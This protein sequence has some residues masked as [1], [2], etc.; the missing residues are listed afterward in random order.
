MNKTL[1]FAFSSFAC[2]L[3]VAC[4]GSSSSDG[5]AQPGDEQD[6]KG[7]ACAPITTL[8]CAAGY[9]ST[10]EGCASP[11]IAGSPPYGRCVST[12]GKAVIGSWAN[13][14]KEEDDLLFYAFTFS[15][16]GTYN[17]TGGCR[18]NPT[19][20]SCFAITK[21]QGKWSVVKSGPQLG[22]PAGADELVLVDQF[23]QKSSYFFTVDGNKLRLSTTFGVGAKQSVFTKQ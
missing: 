22:D 2:A 18:P 16:D 7:G 12:A 17:A 15:S 3:A 4:G 9:E 13:D 11:R 5:S 6:I 23:N 21:A 8:T 14:P 1:A 10:T 20:P 19:G